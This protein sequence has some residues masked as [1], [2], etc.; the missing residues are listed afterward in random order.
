[1]ARP[2]LGSEARAQG[3]GM[4]LLSTLQLWKLREPDPSGEEV[5]FC[6]PGWGLGPADPYPS[7]AGQG[8][9][10]SLGPWDTHS[11][12]WVCMPGGG[13]SPKHQIQVPPNWSPSCYHDQGLEGTRILCILSKFSPCSART[14]LVPLQEVSIQF[15]PTEAPQE[16]SQCQVPL[17]IFRKQRLSEGFP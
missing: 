7:Q 13:G 1:M 5:K 12:L 16:F 6:G 3:L 4:G 14:L 10:Q 2:A 17:N 15:K 9:R 8:G 11:R